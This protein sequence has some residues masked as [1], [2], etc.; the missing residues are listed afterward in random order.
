MEHDDH[1][2]LDSQK[3]ERVST[4]ALVTAKGLVRLAEILSRPLH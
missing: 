3:R 2:Y 1:L 4:R